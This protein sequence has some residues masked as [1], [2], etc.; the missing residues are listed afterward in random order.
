MHYVFTY[1]YNITYLS[2][3]S[4]IYIYIYRERERYTQPYIMMYISE[5]L[6]CAQHVWLRVAQDQERDCKVVL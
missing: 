5:L 1:T 2:F 4:Y 3:Y 6:A